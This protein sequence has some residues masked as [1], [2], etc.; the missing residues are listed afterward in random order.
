MCDMFRVEGCRTSSDPGCGSGASTISTW[1]RRESL[2]LRT[3]AGGFRAGVQPARQQSADHRNTA[4]T[5][6]SCRLSGRSR[7]A[8]CVF[9]RTR[10]A[11]I[12]RLRAVR[13]VCEL[14]HSAV[15]HAASVDEGRRVQSVQQPQGDR[16]EH[17]GAPGSQ[18]AK[19][20][21]WTGHG[22]QPLR[23]CSDSRTRTPTFHQHRRVLPAAGRCEWHSA[24]V[25]ESM[26]RSNR[27]RARCRIGVYGRTRVSAPGADTLVGPCGERFC[28]A[29]LESDPRAQ[30]N[31]ERP[32]RALAV[33]V[34]QPFFDQPVHVRQPSHEAEL[35]FGHHLKGTDADQYTAGRPQAERPGFFEKL[36]VLRG[37]S[38]RKVQQGH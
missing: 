31:R 37:K 16:L 2:R 21:P 32:A 34:A 10:L 15:P 3:V 7:R 27:A 36:A 22:V 4:C 8:G 5:A 26:R 13:H 24:F 18:R 17:L 25:S 12:S 28:N 9:R 30:Q 35:R 19:R 1:P 6:C 20:R 33:D 23:L 38:W 29:L 11:A 14:Q